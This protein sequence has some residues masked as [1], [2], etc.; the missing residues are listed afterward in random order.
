MMQNGHGQ[1]R[2]ESSFKRN[3]GLHPSAWLAT[4][5][6]RDQSAGDAGYVVIELQRQSLHLQR[7]AIVTV[8]SR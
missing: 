8:A 2:P 4:R 5:W 6:R 7:H 3:C 1:K